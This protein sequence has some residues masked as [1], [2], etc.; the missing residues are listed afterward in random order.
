MS[1]WSGRGRAPVI[2]DRVANR[3]YEPRNRPPPPIPDQTRTRRTSDYF[4]G[5]KA[6]YKAGQRAA[7]RDAL[8]A[9]EGVCGERAGYKRRLG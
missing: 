4:A 2:P 9:I 3:P 8:E 5:Y 6:G 1:L 7:M